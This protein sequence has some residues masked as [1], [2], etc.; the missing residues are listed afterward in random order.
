VPSSQTDPQKFLSQ[1]R[2]LIF[3]SFEK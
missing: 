2:R 1:L 3:W